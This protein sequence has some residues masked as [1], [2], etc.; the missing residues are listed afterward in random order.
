M[1]TAKQDIESD[2][3]IIIITI[4]FD[5]KQFAYLLGN[6]VCQEDDECDMGVLQLKNHVSRNQEIEGFCPDFPKRD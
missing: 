6:R 3:I 1:G 2:V 5:L 4:V